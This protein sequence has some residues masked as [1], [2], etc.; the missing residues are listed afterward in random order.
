MQKYLA[1]FVFFFILCKRIA[2]IAFEGNLSFFFFSF[3]WNLLFQLSTEQALAI[4]GCCSLC[5]T[6]FRYITVTVHKYA[7]CGYT[8]ILCYIS[9]STWNM[10]KKRTRNTFKK[11]N[12]RYKKYSNIMKNKFLLKSSQLS[13]IKSEKKLNKS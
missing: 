3:I 2:A 8:W 1:Y 5:D 13:I 4:F 9:K 12:S 10:E 7:Y 11:L 6:L